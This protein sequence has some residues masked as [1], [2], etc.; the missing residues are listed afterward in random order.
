MEKIVHSKPIMFIRSNTWSCT[1]EMFMYRTS[2]SVLYFGIV[3]TDE[4]RQLQYYPLHVR[5]VITNIHKIKQ[6]VNSEARSTSFAHHLMV[7]FILI[8]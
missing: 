3:H 8:S 5:V 2:I 7:Y 4:G 6:L 1:H